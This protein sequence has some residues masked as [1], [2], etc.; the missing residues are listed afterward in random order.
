MQSCAACNAPIEPNEINLTCANCKKV[1]H[2]SEPCTG[3]SPKNITASFKASFCC[4]ACAGEKRHRAAKRPP[5]DIVSP[6]RKSSKTTTAATV[7]CST[8]P[9]REATSSPSSEP[10]LTE[11]F[12]LLERFQ[13]KTAADLEAIKIGNKGALD[14]VKLFSERVQNLERDVGTATST[15]V[16]ASTSVAEIARTNANLE[17]RFTQ[18]ESS[19]NTI[20]ADLD[21]RESPEGG[22]DPL[23]NQLAEDNKTLLRRLINL[24]G[25]HNRL[26]QEKLLNNLIITGISKT[27]DPTAAFWKLVQLLAVNIAKEDVRDIQLLR[28]K[29]SRDSSKSQR[30]A[31][32]TILVKF[33][34]SAPKILLVKKKREIGVAFSN[35]IA[36]LLPQ[37]SAVSKHTAIFFRDHL[38][39][40][41]LNL[42]NKAKEAKSTIG[43]KFVWTKNAEVLMCQDKGSKV[44][45]IRNEIDLETLLAGH[46]DPL[47]PSSPP[48]GP[49][50]ENQTL[51]TST[52][53]AAGTSS[54]LVDTS[55]R[56]SPTSTEVNVT[57][58]PNGP[59]SV[60]PTEPNFEDA[61]P[62]KEAL[63]SQDPT[64]DADP[65]LMIFT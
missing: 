57:A 1:F 34:S 27:L 65:N 61:V 45:K 32:S 37:Q 43:F 56:T 29:V 16:A 5:T 10:T 6:E 39:S 47:N 30:F 14:A 24:E 20:K 8:K 62:A 4:I 46:K 44:F 25:D 3:I 51:T 7:D 11:V 49:I 13:S 58:G 31:T 35:Q 9:S 54:G 15:A 41:S 52:S 53:A 36:E 55:T 63:S 12:R 28:A 22:S 19:V 40:F 59:N 50:V 26:L 21:N 33:A 64:N 23:R 48:S 18:L 42:Y 60:L 2:A 38:S 17:K